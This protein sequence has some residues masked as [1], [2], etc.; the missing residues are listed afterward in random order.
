MQ[1]H[2]PQIGPFFKVRRWN[3]NSVEQLKTELL[4]AIAQD[5]EIG[6]ASNMG[7]EIGTA[8]NEVKSI[9]LIGAAD[10]GDDRDRAARIVAVNTADEV[11]VKNDLVVR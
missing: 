5:P 4:K 1:S 11:E 10:S 9:R 2:E 7:L 6:D 8:G 3:E